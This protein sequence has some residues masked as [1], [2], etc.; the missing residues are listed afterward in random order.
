M[1]DDRPA[2]DELDRQLADR[3]TLDGR[4][5]NRSLATA[6][7]VNQATI[8]AR[9]RRLDAADVMR[10]VAVTD[11]GAFGFQ[12]I[13]FAL[14]DVAGRP[15]PEVAA[16]LARIPEMITVNTVTGACDI[17]GRVIAH[18]R[19]QLA[20]VFGEVIGGVHGVAAVRCE[21]IVDLW[22]SPSGYTQLGPTAGELPP[23]PLPDALDEVDGRVI[24]ILRRD[25]RISNRSIAERLEVSEGTVRNRI[26]RLLEEG[27][28]HIQAACDYQ[29]FG[30]ASGAYVGVR[31]VEG[32]VGEVLEGLLAL[33]EIQVVARTLGSWDFQVLVFRGSHEEFLET[34]HGQI[35]VLPGVGSTTTFAMDTVVK[36]VYTWLQLH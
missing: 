6:L 28:I 12:Y 17:L 32:R 15:V 5:S 14:I 30:R 10:V 13:A 26:R 1:P 4:E 2:I 34:L 21:W 8:A 19:D 27:Y 20:R 24:E 18:D 16:E 23:L 33:E 11:I 31:A 7:D 25:A 35:A 9:L 3:L 29:A 22:R 36:H